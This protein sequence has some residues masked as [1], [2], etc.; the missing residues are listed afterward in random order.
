MGSASKEIILTHL[1]D[2]TACMRAGSVPAKTCTQH[3]TYTNS[4]KTLLTHLWDAAGAFINVRVPCQN[5]V[6]LSDLLSHFEF[7]LI[8]SSLSSRH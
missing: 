2:L 4:A 5:A 6:I 8:I 1:Q 3:P 7:A